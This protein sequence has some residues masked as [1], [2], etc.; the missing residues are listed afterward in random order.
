MD[1]EERAYAIALQAEE[2]LPRGGRQISQ[3]Q[4]MLP[5]NVMQVQ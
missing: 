3:A 4:V 1:V 5:Q 2:T